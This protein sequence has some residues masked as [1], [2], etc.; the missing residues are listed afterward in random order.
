MTPDDSVG[1]RV[2]SVNPTLRFV[3]MDFPFRKMPA[4]EQRLNIYRNG[5]KIGE[6]KVTGPSLD[7]TIAGDIITGEAQIGD[8]VRED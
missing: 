7:T 1:G 5:Q 2:A 3:V 4:L 8:E 6:V